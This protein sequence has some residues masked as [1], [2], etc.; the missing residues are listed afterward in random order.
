MISRSFLP[1][2]LSHCLT[3]QSLLAEGLFE[4]LHMTDRYDRSSFSPI[5]Q[6]WLHCVIP[7]RKGGC[8]EVRIPFYPSLVAAVVM[9]GW[10][11]CYKLLWSDSDHESPSCANVSGICMW[12]SIQCVSQVKSSAFSKIKWYEVNWSWHSQKLHKLLFRRNANLIVGRYWPNIFSRVGDRGRQ[13]EQDEEWGIEIEKERKEQR[14]K[15]LILFVG[16]LLHSFQINKHAH[17]AVVWY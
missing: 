4:K 8:R 13:A 15:D 9:M 5:D 12:S 17:V 11:T 14:E 1:P 10:L 7:K 3:H 2:R 6:R 16:N